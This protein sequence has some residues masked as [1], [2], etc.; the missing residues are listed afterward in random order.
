LAWWPYTHTR[1]PATRLSTKLMIVSATPPPLP[2][3]MLEMSRELTSG[4]LDSVPSTDA[5]PAPSHK[6]TSTAKA[7]ADSSAAVK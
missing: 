1:P 7:M 3:E 6:P 4:P 5:P 2:T